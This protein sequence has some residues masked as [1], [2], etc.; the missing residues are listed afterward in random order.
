[1]QLYLV[2]N[3]MKV[4][5][6]LQYNHCCPVAS[7]VALYFTYFALACY[8]HASGWLPLS[9]LPHNILLYNDYTSRVW[10]QH[11]NCNVQSH[12]CSIYTA[13]KII[14]VIASLLA[15][16]SSWVERFK[17]W[18]EKRLTSSVLAKRFCDFAMRT[19]IWPWRISSNRT[20][21]LGIQCTLFLLFVG[22]L[23]EICQLGA[24]S[25]AFLCKIRVANIK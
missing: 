17:R 1:M 25:F 7:L 23:M 10:F 6:H 24:S 3:K 8:S 5:H 22:N 11:W 16:S 13:Y 4:N 12:V 9:F 21:H 20:V 2:S 18:R 14:A 19:T 15:G